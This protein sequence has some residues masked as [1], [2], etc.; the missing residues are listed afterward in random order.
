MNIQ[1]TWINGLNNQY[2]L[3]N[4]IYQ[5]RS[6]LLTECYT[7]FV[8]PLGSW[9]LNPLFGSRFP[10]WINTR[11]PITSNKLEQELTR[12]YSPIKNENRV[13]DITWEVD[14]LTASSIS[15]ILSII[16]NNNKAIPLTLSLKGPN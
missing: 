11:T 6:N 7:R 15:I 5:K 16:D 3:V 8:V 13:K 2:N 9:I 4:G 14:I 1:T 10:L 12:I